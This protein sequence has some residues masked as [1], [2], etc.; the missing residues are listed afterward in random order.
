MSKIDKYIER[1]GL[2]LIKIEKVDLRTLH[3]QHRHGVNEDDSKIINSPQVELA[4]L[5]YE[6]GLSWLVT[7]FSKTK[8]YRFQKDILKNTPC[9]PMKKVKLFKS[10][11]S[12]YLRGKH[13]RDYILILQTPFINS[14]FSID[15]GF[16]PE[17]FI[18]HHRAGAL[19]SLGINF[20]DVMVAVDKKSGECECYGKL[21][22]V[23]TDYK[24]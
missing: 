23:Y 13:N 15:A 3:T 9:F 7:N 19:L 1:Y 5:Y 11:K 20:A 6:R 8:Y 21:N 17:V 16:G 22:K 4:N 14:R 10:I 18:G 24:L 2:E 12:G